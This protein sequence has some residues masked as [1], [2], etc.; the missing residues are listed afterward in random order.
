MCEKSCYFRQDAR[1]STS[2]GSHLKR[3]LNDEEDGAMQLFGKSVQGQGSFSDSDLEH[4]QQAKDTGS[5]ENE[6]ESGGQGMI[7]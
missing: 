6:R 2:E 5:V 3:D 7:M 4:S 1:K